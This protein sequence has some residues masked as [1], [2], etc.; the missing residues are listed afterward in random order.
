MI[1]PTGIIIRFAAD[2]DNWKSATPTDAN[3]GLAVIIPSGADLLLQMFFSQGAI[4]DA[5]ALDYTNIAT[6]YVSL[7]SS[8][9]P[10]NATIY[11]S[12]SIANAAITA[13]PVANWLAGNGQHIQVAIPN[14]QNAF[15][16]TSSQQNY[17]L[18][19][20][21]VTNDATPRQII[22]AAC[23]VTVAD[24][25]LPIAVPTLPQTFKVGTKVSFVC[26][27]G[28]TRD[29]SMSKLGN[30]AW[31]LAVG[32]V[33]YNGGGQGTYSFFCADG[34]FRDLTVQLVQGVWTVDIA[35][36]GHS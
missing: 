19:I 36:G 28:L 26:S 4:S 30:G 8:N 18:V 34:L 14:A 16:A 1:Q 22:F 2:I 29:L 20:Y 9:S 10:H 23:Q 15:L 27:D 21:G 25:G 11:W 6:V 33:G 32:Q 13:C 31:S 5:T 3:T 17:W 35:Q 24:S 12:A 7:Q